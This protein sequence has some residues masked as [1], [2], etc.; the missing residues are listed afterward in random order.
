MYVELKRGYIIPQSISCKHK[1][2]DRRFKRKL[3]EKKKDAPESKQ[4]ESCHP[5]IQPDVVIQ[6]F[7]RGLIE[8][9][10]TIT[11]DAFCDTS[12]K[13]SFV[14]LCLFSAC[15]THS[16]DTHTHT[17]SVVLCRGVLSPQ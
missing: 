13:M 10:A 14:K 8:A 11:T 5:V 4:L 3:Q 16:E 9:T 12:D 1:P 6:H 2:S 17:H 15:K 7:S